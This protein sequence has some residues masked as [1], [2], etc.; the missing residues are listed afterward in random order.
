M[1]NTILFFLCYFS[2]TFI[3]GQITLTNSNTIFTNGQSISFNKGN[4]LAPGP[5]GSNQ[6][7]DYSSI[8]PVS[9]LTLSVKTTT[10]STYTY[11]NATNFTVSDSINNQ[12]Y[13]YSFFN[14]SAVS[15][16]D[17]K[18][19]NDCI[20]SH[21]L[22]LK[23]PFSYGDSVYRTNYCGVYNDCAGT[24]GGTQTYKV[25]FDGYGTLK[26]PSVTLHNV[27]RIGYFSFMDVH[28]GSSTATA[29]ATVYCYYLPNVNYPVAQSIDKFQPRF[30][31]PTIVTKEFIYQNSISLGIKEDDFSSAVSV[32]PNPTNDYLNVQLNKVCKKINCTI[33]DIYG[34]T[35]LT[36][37]VLD[38]NINEK[39]DIS[40]LQNGT[41]LIEINSDKSSITK[42]FI[43]LK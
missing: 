19:A 39:I 10:N 13:Y 36:T 29:G 24:S 40:I 22:M 14:D 21:H 25:K 26:L 27:S 20:S 33:K 15:F 12:S 18:F 7:W 42:K 5:A 35:I 23:Y 32:Y 37:H 16:F 31:N 3:K 38:N 2:L 9:T 11:T 1:K 43:V 28:C 17:N 4:Y 34:N 41:Y 30:H 8:I 6:T